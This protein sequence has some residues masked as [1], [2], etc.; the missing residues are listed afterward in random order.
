MLEW[1]TGPD[2]GEYTGFADTKNAL[3]EPPATPGPVFAY[4]AFKNAILGTPAVEKE[5]EDDEPA[6]RTK[7]LDSPHLQPTEKPVENTV[8]ETKP[9]HKPPQLLPKTEPPP[10]PM[11]S[12]TK[13]ILLTPGATATRRKTV[14]FGEGVIDNERKKSSLETSPKK[15]APVGAISRQWAATLADGTRRNRSKFTQ[16]L[17]DARDKKSSSEE[18]ELFNI[19]K[20]RDDST[21]SKD[22]PPQPQVAEPG[23]EA[24]GNI[25]HRK[26][27]PVD[28]EGDVTTNLEEPRSQSGIYWKSEYESYKAKTNQEIKK[29]LQYRSAAKSY[30]KKKEAEAVRLADKLKREEEKVAEMERRVAELA[31]GIAD[32]QGTN[33]EDMVKEL[34]KQ[35]TLA[36][37]YKQKTESLRKVLER[38][39]VLEDGSDSNEI[40]SDGLAQKLRETQAALEKANARLKAAEQ[41][42]NVNELQKLAAASEAKVKELEKENLSLKRNLA[43]VKEEMSKYEE[44]RKAKEARL[45][46]REQKLESRIREYSARLRESTRQHREAEEEMKNSFAAEKKQL[47]DII[48]CLRQQ[49]QAAERATREELRHPDGSRRTTRAKYSQEFDALEDLDIKPARALKPKNSHLRQ[50][51]LIDDEGNGGYGSDQDGVIDAQLSSRTKQNHAKDTEV[52]KFLEIDFDERPL[53]TFEDPTPK[54]PR[55]STTRR[56]REK[57]DDLIPPSSPP[58]L[59]MESSVMISPN[60]P[61]HLTR[62]DPAPAP[63]PRP[64]MVYMNLGSRRSADLSRPQG[65]K[66]ILSPATSDPK[67]SS[68]VTATTSSRLNRQLSLP[69]NIDALPNS[70]PKSTGGS[71]LDAIPPDRLAAAKARLKHRQAEGSRV[72]RDEKENILV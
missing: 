62:T 29:L 22:K 7:P 70:S 43:R 49:L 63:S 71:R 50:P 9:V 18:D 35:T 53:I 23:D 51:S 39:G 44:R 45:K 14:S 56:R 26:E 69:R 66:K 54:K 32:G 68:R 59:N 27:T 47:Q 52:D 11:G 5:L 15:A 48:S 13:S 8:E 55:S 36:L 12:P 6:A 1:L 33:R 24:K 21:S 37:Q 60:I 25:V 41:G 72:R 19:A 16:S 30:A 64:S 67:V 10:Q 3:P 65:D 20:K 17:L 2:R 4:R 40:T 34:S 58:L 61:K 46:Q 42:P 28:D 31:A 38:H 57:N